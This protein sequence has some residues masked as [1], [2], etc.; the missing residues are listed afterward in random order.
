MSLLRISFSTAMRTTHYPPRCLLI[1]AITA[2]L[3]ASPVV[4][5]PVDCKLNSAQQTEHRCCCGDHCECVAC[6]CI[7]SSPQTP[8]QSPVIPDHGRDLMK[9]QVSAIA[10]KISPFTVVHAVEVAPRFAPALI[11]LSTLVLQHTCLQV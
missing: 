5:R 7:D 6:R 1:V 2:G 4:G 8:P 3:T 9:L 11:S 10:V